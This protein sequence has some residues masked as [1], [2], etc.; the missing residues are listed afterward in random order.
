M[1]NELTRE[2]IK[3]ILYEIGVTKIIDKA[4]KPNLQINC[5]IHGESTPSMGVHTETLQVHCFACHFSGSLQ[6]LVYKAVDDFRNTI[7]VEKWISKKYGVTFDSKQEDRQAL[8]NL[9]RFDELKV[10]AKE[11]KGRHELKRTFLAPFKSGK[12]T[13]GYFTR[14][15]FTKKTMQDF[16]IGRDLE[17]KT[18]TIPVYWEDKVLCGVVGRY[19]DP[20]R[21]KNS[22]Y[23]LYEF[24]K[25]SITYPQDKLEVIDDTII[26]V[27]GI[28]DALWLHQ[29]GFPNAQS[30]LGNE[31][32]EDQVKYL[33]K[34]ATKFIVMTDNDS[35]GERATERIKKL[36][37]REVKLFSVTYPLNKKDAQECSK[38]EIE[39]MIAN[40][41]SLGSIKLKRI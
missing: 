31:I 39:D 23:K 38:E 18:V 4:G 8:R 20:N 36:M 21:P 19:I 27:E 26:I 40:K 34:K 33:K 37:G 41:E 9:K 7:E 1:S 22:R 15:G 13:Y 32:S 16:M 3:D 17:S 12:E 28:L 30:I 2:Q 14:R 35:G 10:A 29:L 5:P 6:W 25:A 24:P 11:D